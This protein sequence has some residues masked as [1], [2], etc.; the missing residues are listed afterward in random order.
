MAIRLEL[1]PAWT[2]N[3]AEGLGWTTGFEMLFETRLIVKGFPHHPLPKSNVFV[4]G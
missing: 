4:C 3:A 1:E 2:L